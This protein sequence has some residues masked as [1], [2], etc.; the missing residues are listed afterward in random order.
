MKDTDTDGVLDPFVGTWQ[1]IDG[2][3]T[4]TI[5]FVKKTNWNPLNLNNYTEDIILGD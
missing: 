1:W 4:F 2:T 5:K 3:N